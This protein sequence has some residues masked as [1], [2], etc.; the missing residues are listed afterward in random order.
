MLLISISVATLHTCSSFPM[1]LMSAKKQEEVGKQ[2]IKA[3]LA[4]PENKKCFDCPTRS[5]FFVNISLQTFVCTR[6]SGLV[7][8]VGHRVKSISTSTFSGP[9]ILA[10]QQGGNGIASTLWLS[11]YTMQSQEVETDDDV[12]MF[13]R[14]KYYEQK[15]LDA[16]LLKEHTL[17]V[18]EKIKYMFNEEGARRPRVSTPPLPGADKDATSTPADPIQRPFLPPT[19]TRLQP[20]EKDLLS[21]IAQPVSL[22][23]A[24]GAQTPGARSRLSQ[25]NALGDFQGGFQGKNPS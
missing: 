14:Q 9:E 8:E 18:A 15:W 17:Q 19:E 1:S 22:H 20:K 11:K 13:M 5:P 25:G 24:M 21:D 23:E 16:A 10:L 3:L 4:L 7:R 2:K 12:R 6:C